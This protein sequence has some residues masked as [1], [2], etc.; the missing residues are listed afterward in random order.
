MTS[1]FDARAAAVGSPLEL[2]FN[3]EPVTREIGGDRAAVLSQ[4]AIVHRDGVNDENQNGRS[5]VYDYRMEVGAAVTV[6]S[7]DTYRI[8]CVRC[9]VIRIGD[10]DNGLKTV[11]LQRVDDQWTEAKGTEFFR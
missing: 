3:G 9:R 11:W 4:T 5:F 1:A 8:D 10:P 6:G 2:R 7:E